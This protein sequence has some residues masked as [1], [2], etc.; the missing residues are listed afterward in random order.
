MR[1]TRFLALMLALILLVSIVPVPALAAA[2]SATVIPMIF[3]SAKDKFADVVGIIVDRVEELEVDSAAKT[4]S[5]ETFV[6]YDGVN[7]DLV[8]IYAYPER[9]AND[10]TEEEW[11]KWEAD[12]QKWVEETCVS[13]G[14]TSAT[15]PA[16]PRNGTEEEKAKWQAQFELFIAAYAPHSHAYTDWHTNATNHWKY[17]CICKENFLEMDWHIDEDNDDICD[18]C[19]A[20]IVYYDITVAEAEGGKIV[21]ME[22][23]KDSTAAYRDTIEISV[24]ADDGY[25][26][27]D[28]RF[29]KVREDG[30]RSQIMRTVIERGKT[31][32]FVM[33]SFDVEI[34]VTYAKA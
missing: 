6:T 15:I 4:V 29:Y 16:F 2:N 17:C 11:A 24:E 25:V 30:T 32:S 31:Y 21:E 13:N 19:E 23:D 27:K 20:E 22:G 9:P 3:N 33:P 26:V 8:G 12:L 5:P 34:V 28:V 14:K 1:K 10:A 7:Y 18:V